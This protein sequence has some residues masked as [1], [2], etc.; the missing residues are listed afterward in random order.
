MASSIVIVDVIIGA[1]TDVQISFRKI[2]RKNSRARHFALGS[3]FM[4]YDALGQSGAEEQTASSPFGRRV[5]SPPGDLSKRAD[6]SPLRQSRLSTSSSMTFLTDWTEHYLRLGPR[7]WCDKHGPPRGEEEDDESQK[8]PITF[9]ALGDWKDKRSGR[10]VHR[11][12]LEAFGIS[13]EKV[14]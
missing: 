8:I 3:P 6:F 11:G 1:V 12:L 10:A 9:D 14:I 7:Y 4:R 2:R 5:Q 13:R